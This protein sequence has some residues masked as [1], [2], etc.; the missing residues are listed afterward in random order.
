MIDRE[1]VIEEMRDRRKR[2]RFQLARAATLGEKM[3]LEGVLAGFADCETL[4]RACRSQR[5]SA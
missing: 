2:V 3:Y 5:E 4:L 1:E